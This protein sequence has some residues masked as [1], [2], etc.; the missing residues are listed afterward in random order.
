MMKELGYTLSVDELIQLRQHDVTA[1]FTSN[2]HDLGYTDITQDELVRLRDTGVTAS[3]VEQL[4]EQRGE[5][6]SIEEIIRYSISNQ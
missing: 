3:E 6:P 4:I 1:Y 5:Q 2:M